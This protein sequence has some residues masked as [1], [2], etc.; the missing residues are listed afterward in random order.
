M[1]QKYSGNL[2]NSVSS[3]V[4][5]NAPSNMFIQNYNSNQSLYPNQGHYALSAN[6]NSMNASYNPNQNHNFL[7][8]HTQNFYNQGEPPKQQI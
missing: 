7:Y 4:S 3:N 6:Y 1:R 8:S 2:P 5:C